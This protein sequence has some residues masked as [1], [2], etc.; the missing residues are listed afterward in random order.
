MEPFFTKSH[1][2]CSSNN[3]FVS[4]DIESCI[5]ECP[6]KKD[7]IKKFK[8][9]NKIYIYNND[10]KTLEEIIVKK[11]NSK[12]FNKSFYVYDL[13]FEDMENG[14]YIAN[15]LLVNSQE[16][17]YLSNPKIACIISCIAFN[18]Y[19]KLHSFL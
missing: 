1:P 15:N 12:V 2:L 19:K 8:I 17:N 9:N 10:S 7:L 11:I 6:E 18:N 13:T 16:P 3:E 5:K 14:T 4:L